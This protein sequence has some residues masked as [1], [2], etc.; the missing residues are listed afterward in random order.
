MQGRVFEKI[1][2][3]DGRIQD[4]DSSKI[5]QAITKAGQATGE[6]GKDVAQRL[7]I[8][9][10]N[11]ATQLIKDRYPTVEEIQDIVEEVLINSPYKKTAKAYILSLIHI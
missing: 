8:R 2:K 5:C 3:R 1:V 4:F 7:T 6:F 9:V 11:L 10:L